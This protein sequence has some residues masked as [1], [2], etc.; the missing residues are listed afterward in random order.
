MKISS[1]IPVLPGLPE[2]G[3]HQVA[4]ITIAG[5]MVKVQLQLVPGEN[6]LTP[7]V[8]FCLWADEGQM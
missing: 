2:A 1:L 3:L 7:E 5:P 4:V 6:T 8:D